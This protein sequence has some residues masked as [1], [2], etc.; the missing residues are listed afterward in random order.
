MKVEPIV[1]FITSL[2][3]LDWLGFFEW[4]EKSLSDWSHVYVRMEDQ[5]CL[6]G[7]IEDGYIFDCKKA[8]FYDFETNKRILAEC[9][10]YCFKS[11]PYFR[12]G[13]AYVLVSDLPFF[14][15]RALVVNYR[16]GQ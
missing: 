13:E 4:T 10:R 8:M 3:V 14:D 6:E 12:D 7:S 2:I 9:V 11:E 5:N 16:Y 15:K 1:I